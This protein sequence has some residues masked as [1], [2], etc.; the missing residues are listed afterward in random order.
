MLFQSLHTMSIWK[1][2]FKSSATIN[3][4]LP[5]GDNAST[6]HKFDHCYVCRFAF[7]GYIAKDFSHQLYL[8]CRNPYFFYWKQLFRFPV[9]VF[10][11]GPWWNSLSVYFSFLIIFHATSLIYFLDN[12]YL[13][14]NSTIPLSLGER[15]A[16]EY[17]NH[18]QWKIY[19]PY[20]WVSAML[21]A[22]NTYWNSKRFKK[23]TIKA[24]QSMHQV[25]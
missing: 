5:V 18:F 23:P 21:Q 11:R 13:L 16:E 7:S 6:H 22:Q 12:F 1:T 8:V 14:N 9:V 2:A 3:T 10:P 20:S 25:A 24:F 4:M 17:Y 19:K 15:T